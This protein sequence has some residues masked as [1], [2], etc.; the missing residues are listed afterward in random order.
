MT[1]DDATAF[2][3]ATAWKWS[4]PATRR[5]ALRGGRPTTGTNPASRKFNAWARPC[6]PYPKIAIDLPVSGRNDAERITRM[7]W[8]SG[9]IIR[10]LQK[11]DQA[12]K[13]F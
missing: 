2:V 10:L 9:T 4:R 7:V 1:S 12:N 8:S 13:S 6:E 11:A 5:E 3:G